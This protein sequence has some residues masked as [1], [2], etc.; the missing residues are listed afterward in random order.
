MSPVSELFKRP[1]NH[2]ITAITEILIGYPLNR[3][4]EEMDRTVGEDE[5]SAIAGVPA[6]RAVIVDDWPTENLGAARA[7]DD[8]GRTRF[9]QR[10]FIAAHP[11][12]PNRPIVE[13]RNVRRLAQRDRLAGTVVNFSEGNVSIGAPERVQ[14][15][16]DM[17]EHPPIREPVAGFVI[18][19]GVTRGCTA[20]WCMWRQR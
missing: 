5:L 16:G 19:R 13:R 6:E 9:E 7:I 1:K 4:R 20:W 12:D 11:A 3:F 10:R 18:R 8:R 15:V 17:E 2:P 14:S